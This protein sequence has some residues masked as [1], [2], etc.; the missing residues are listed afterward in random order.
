MRTV[1]RGLSWA[2]NLCNAQHLGLR[3]VRFV[4]RGSAATGAESHDR[5]I[6]LNLDLRGPCISLREH[7]NPNPGKLEVVG[8]VAFV[9]VSAA[10][11]KR[12]P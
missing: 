4:E 7:W 5:A 9:V 1:G 12:F 3:Q 10:G 11:D 8:D 2:H 6:L